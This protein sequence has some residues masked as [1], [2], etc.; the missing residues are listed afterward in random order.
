MVDCYESSPKNRP[1]RQTNFERHTRDRVSETSAHLAQGRTHM[2][3]YLPDDAGWMLAI[4]GLGGILGIL[5]HKHQPSGYRTLRS[6]FASREPASSKVAKREWAIG[7]Y[8]G[9]SPWDLA[10]SGRVVNP[11]LTRDD[12]NDVDA[13]LL[14]DPFMIVREGVYYLFFEIRYY[15]YYNN[16]HQL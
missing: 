8:E 10:E 15:N 14:A 11:V 7:I 6:L 13:E 4:F 9:T 12:V 3:S 1:S 16:D 5:V 2:I